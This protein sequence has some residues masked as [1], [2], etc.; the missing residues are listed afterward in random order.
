MFVE[1]ALPHNTSMTY[2]KEYIHFTSSHS[3]HVGIIKERKQL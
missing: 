1:G 3:H 2:I